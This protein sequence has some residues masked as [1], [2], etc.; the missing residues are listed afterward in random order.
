MLRSEDEGEAAIML[1]GKPLV[2]L[3]GHMRRVIVKDDLDS[4]SEGPLCQTSC[5]LNRIVARLLPPESSS[6]EQVSR[7]VAISVATLERWRAAALA[8]GSGAGSPHW[9]AAARLRSS[10]KARTHDPPGQLDLGDYGPCEERVE[11]QRGLLAMFN[12]LGDRG[13]PGFVLCHVDRGDPIDASLATGDFVACRA[14][15]GAP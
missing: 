6:V 4:R 9:T 13:K 10:I 15:S 14:T 1:G 3:L 12:P 7:A 11:Q 5:H 2:R 8:N